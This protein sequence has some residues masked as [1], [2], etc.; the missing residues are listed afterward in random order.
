MSR[1]WLNHTFVSWLTPHHRPKTNR[2][3]ASLVVQ[4]RADAPSRSPL[5][6]PLL[7]RLLGSF[8]GILK[9]GLAQQGI[10][11]WTVRERVVS[12]RGTRWGQC[13]VLIVWYLE[14]GQLEGEMIAEE[15]AAVAPKQNPRS[16]T[17]ARNHGRRKL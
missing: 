9:I 2:S 5:Q 3:V 15:A 11:A 8:V 13:L 17:R 10:G 1:K 7:S 14:Q 16:L 4:S 6:I 12:D